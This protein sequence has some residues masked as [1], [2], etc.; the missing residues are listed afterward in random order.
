MVWKSGAE[1]WLV[2]TGWNGEG[3]KPSVS[4]AASINDLSGTGP[5]DRL[6]F[7]QRI[8]RAFQGRQRGAVS[9][10]RVQRMMAGR[11]ARPIAD[12]LQ[13]YSDTGLH[14]AL[15]AVRRSLVSTTDLWR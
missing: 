4:P 6:V 3:Q 11:Q 8:R 5:P 2:S 10:V 12:I 14:L 7:I 1:A 9:R 15:A 13:Q